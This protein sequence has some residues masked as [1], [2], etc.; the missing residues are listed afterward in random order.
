MIDDFAFSLDDIEYGVLR[1][2]GPRNNNEPNQFLVG[3]QRLKFMVQIMDYRGHFAHN[4]SSLSCP[5]LACYSQ[6]K[7][8]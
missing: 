2:N 7:N 3:D 4:C 6:G 1:R 5:P 8:R